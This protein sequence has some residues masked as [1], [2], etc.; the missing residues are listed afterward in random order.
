MPSGKFVSYSRVSTSRQ[1]VSGLGLDAQRKAISDYLNG[2]DWEL[3]GEFVEIESGKKDDRKEL[4]RAL[5]MCLMTGS[6]LLI[7][8]LD[9]L[10][11][12]LH[13]ISSL[14]KAG[15]EFVAVDMPTANRFTVHILAA[16]AEHERYM[17][18]QRTKVALAAARARGKVL[19]NP[20]NLSAD[21]ASKGRKLGVEANKTKAI[22]FALKVS[23]IFNEFRSQGLNLRQIAEEL[24]ARNI[25]TASGRMGCW[26]PSSV[27][28]V[29]LRLNVSNLQPALLAA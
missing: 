21:D 15:V 5:H 17:I 7:A 1:G 13:F 26:C 24:N 8:K 16:V 28:D 2:G 14:Q 22:Q 9:R 4:Q 27:R 18:S 29:I 11:R 23:P 20:A 19:G 6:T 25:L 3:L 10:S 12:D